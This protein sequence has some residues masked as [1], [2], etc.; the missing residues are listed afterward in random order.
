MEDLKPKDYTHRERMQV[1]ILIFLLPLFALLFLFSLVGVLD[2]PPFGIEVEET[3]KNKLFLVVLLETLALIS[4]IIYSVFG[5]K[6]TQEKNNLKE[7][8]SNP[9][10]NFINANERAQETLGGKGVKETIEQII[11]NLEKS[12]E[13][14]NPT[15]HKI[16][17]NKFQPI[18]S[19]SDDWSKGLLV[20]Q[21]SDT[22]DVTF[23]MYNCAK[24][25]MFVT[26]VPDYR[27]VWSTEYG[28]KL[29]K[30]GVYTERVFIFQ[31]L[32]EV[33]VTD[34]EIMKEQS[35]IPNISVKVLLIDESS[36]NLP[37]KVGNDFAII[38]DGEIIGVT[39]S[40]RNGVEEAWYFDTTSVKSTFLEIRKKIEMWSRD[41][42][43]YH[44]KDDKLELNR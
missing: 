23:E 18:M 42:S 24:K 7:E 30:I 25:A 33:T 5:I 4:A 32:E 35:A 19:E 38:D 27:S 31:N 9:E 41:F 3:F 2:N 12:L 28:N 6:N 10:V 44:W 26:S 22:H 8:Q 34:F 1:T 13:I 43:Q 21:E 17:N 20:V 37:I 39:K 36:I 16:I 40:F 11:T 14:K 29:L 15:F